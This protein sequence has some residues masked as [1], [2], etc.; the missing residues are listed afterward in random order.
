MHKERCVQV[1]I[2]ILL[3]VDAYGKGEEGIYY[4]FLTCC[5]FLNVTFV[6]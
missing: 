4:P 1:H 2:I 5:G 3:T 6:N